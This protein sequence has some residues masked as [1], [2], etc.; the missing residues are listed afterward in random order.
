MF[1]KQAF[2]RGSFEVAFAQTLDAL[3]QAESITRRE[4]RDVS[5]SILTAIHCTEDSGFLNR[6]IGVLT[7]VNKKVMVEYLKHFSGFHYDDRV[8]LFTKKNKPTYEKASQLSEEFLSEPH[9]NVWTWAERNIEV[10][11][12]PF[13]VNAITKQFSNILKKATDN[14]ISQKDVFKAVLA[15]GISVDAMIDMLDELGYAEVVEPTDVVSPVDQ[16]AP[17]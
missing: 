6:L 7:P 1:N 14:G 3:G 9:N 10:T 5:R 4:L 16:P 15:S 11:V 8:M 17:F 2:N 12:K 13:D